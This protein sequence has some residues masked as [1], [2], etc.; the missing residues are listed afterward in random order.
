M[1]FSYE[2]LHTNIECQDFQIFFDIFKFVFLNRCICT[3]EPKH[4][5]LIKLIIISI[6]L[7]KYIF[8]IIKKLYLAVGRNKTGPHMSAVGH[9]NGNLCLLRT[10]AYLNQKRENH[11]QNPLPKPVPVPSPKPHKSIPVDLRRRR[12]AAAMNPAGDEA[13]AGKKSRHKDKK[14]KKTKR[15]DTTE[16]HGGEPEDEAVHKKKKKKHTS[17]KGDPKRKPT[18][19]IAIA[20]SIIDNAQSLELATLVSTPSPIAFPLHFLHYRS[21]YKSGAH[22]SYFSWPV[23]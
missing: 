19:S 13:A 2:Y 1:L 10:R 9:T 23:R 8:E 22:L 16:H 15:K 21:L 5:L 7:T 14:E 18:V 3:Y 12:R 20:G 4:H 11:Y 17:E 6:L